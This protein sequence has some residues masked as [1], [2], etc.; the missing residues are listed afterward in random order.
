LRT[1]T[2]EDHVA[3]ELAR[4]SYNPQRSWL[5]RITLGLAFV[6][7]LTLLI[8]LFTDLVC[9]PVMILGALAA[10]SAA[11]WAAFEWRYRTDSSLRG[12]LQAGLAGQHLVPQI[13]SVLDNRYYLI[14]NLNLPGRADDVDHIVIGPN[15]IF[16]L[17]TKNHRGRILWREGEWIQ[18]KMS[19]GGHPQPDAPMRDPAQQLKRNI[20]YLRWCINRTD[21]GLSR[22]TRLWIEG[23]V[24][25]THPAVAVD[26]PEEVLESLPFPVLRVR[27]LPAHITGHVPRRTHSTLE[28]RQIISMLGHLKVPYSGRR[29]N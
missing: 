19:R 24:V 2:F 27:D 22:R 13:L 15:G 26:L 16:A 9:W 7:A 6:A 28:I 10:L 3:H 23:L 20:D 21:P 5:R 12:K 18:S 29:R 25:F 17:E 4:A 8:T 11:L 1:I 14:N